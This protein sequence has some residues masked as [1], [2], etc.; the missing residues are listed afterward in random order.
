MPVIRAIIPN[1]I[2]SMKPSKRKIVRTV[3]TTEKFTKSIQKD[4]PE[5]T[6]GLAMMISDMC[7]TIRLHMTKTN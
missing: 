2:S 4:I 1:Q 5:E 3:Y 7:K 6:R